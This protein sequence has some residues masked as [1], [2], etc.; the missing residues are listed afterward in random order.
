[1]SEE[2]NVYIPPPLLLEDVP[3]EAESLEE[4]LQLAAVNRLRIVVVVM[5]MPVARSQ[6]RYGNGQPESDDE[7]IHNQFHGDRQPLPEER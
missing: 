5:T 7:R 4:I 6:H 1:M 3:S 2:P